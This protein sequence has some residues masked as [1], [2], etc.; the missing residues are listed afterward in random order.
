MKMQRQ[1]GVNRAK[2]Y[3][4]VLFPAEQRCHQR[5]LCTG[6]FLHC[7]LW[8]QCTGAGYPVCL[9]H[10]HGHAPVRCHHRPHH[11]CA[12]G[13]HQR[14]VRQV[15][16]VHGHRQPDYG[17]QHPDSVRHH[18]H[19]SRHHDVGPLCCLCRAVFRLGHRL[20][21]PDQLHPLRPDGAD[22]RPQAAPAVHHLQHRR[23]SA[24]HGRYAVLCPHPG[25]EL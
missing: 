16:P 23:L 24:G 8:Q 2:L 1:S 20:H 7:Y 19:D 18:P 9:G 4:L 22:Q 25:Q 14:Q 10:G 17:R 21:L 5:I 13:P 12:D 6:A 3:Q 11:R 15:P